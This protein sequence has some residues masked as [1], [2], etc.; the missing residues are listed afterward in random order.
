MSV[1]D[2]AEVE[3]EGGT[4]DVQRSFSWLDLFREGVERRM[5]GRARSKRTTFT[6]SKADPVWISDRSEEAE[7]ML[8]RSCASEKR[9]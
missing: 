7:D 4:E 8:G 5:S 9:L 1:P 2:G 3:K 6:M